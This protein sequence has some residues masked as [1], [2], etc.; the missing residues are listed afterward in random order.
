MAKKGEN[1]SYFRFL[2]RAHP[3]GKAYYD[4][5]V[6]DMTGL[7]PKTYTHDQPLIPGV[8]RG[9]RFASPERIKRERQKWKALTLRHLGDVA[10]LAQW[11]IAKRK[12]P[13]SE[14]ERLAQHDIERINRIRGQ[15]FQYRK[16]SGEFMALGLKQLDPYKFYSARASEATGIPRDS[17]AFNVDFRRPAEKL[18]EA[19]ERAQAEGVQLGPAEEVLREMDSRRLRPS[20]QDGDGFEPERRPTSAP[21]AT[22]SDEEEEDDDTEDCDFI[23]WRRGD[24]M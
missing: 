15:P 19:V 14:D 12:F 20:M 6:T 3:G 23:Q 18:D 7:S 8:F 4:E 11:D 21:C 5:L 10:G 16:P 1:P 9:L 2:K 13:K 17:R 22:E 24:P